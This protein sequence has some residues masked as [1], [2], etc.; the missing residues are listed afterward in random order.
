MAEFYIGANDEHGV[1]PP[2]VGKRT[3]IMPYINRAIYE[4]EFNRPAKIFFL[5]ACMRQDFDTYDVKPELQDLSVSSR[6]RRINNQG[7]TLLVTFAYNAFGS[8]NSFNSASGAIAFYSDLNRQ[9]AR[10]RAL[11]ED[12]YEELTQ[13]DF[14]NGLGVGVLDIGVLSSVNCPSALIETGFMT[15][16]EEA[17]LM[18]N[19]DFQIETAEEACRG[20]CRYLNVSYKDRGELGNY[21]TLRRG[22]RGNYVKLAQSLLNTAGIGLEVDGVFG[23]DTLAAVQGFQNENGLA[24]DGV[25]GPN[26][27][28]ALLWLPPYPVLRR[29]SRG[30][31]VR[32]LQ[33]LLL[34]KLYDPGSIDGVFGSLTQNAV[35]AFQRENGLVV[36][37]IVG[38]RTW[39]SLKV[40]RGRTR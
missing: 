34:S 29:G 15:N 7:L 35:L 30:N 27:W 33:Q 20:V 14:H 26:T 39:S 36:D 25:I 37:G 3:P 11:A 32:Y 21:P 9:V 16:F 1:N 10:S 4:N 18:L 23:G 24:I 40:S 8:G 22:S 13:G 28:R 2:T 12:L 17:K 6:V 5:Q 31:Y 38:S 19:P